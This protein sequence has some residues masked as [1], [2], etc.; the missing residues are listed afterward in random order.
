M[1]WS[2]CETIRRYRAIRLGEHG[3]GLLVRNR[4][5][6]AFLI[7]VM[8][9][10]AAGLL[11]SGCSP[12]SVCPFDSSLED[13]RD[14]RDVGFR[15]DIFDV[16]ACSGMERSPDLLDRPAVEGM[17][18]TGEPVLVI[19][20]F[21]IAGWDGGAFDL[22]DD[23]AGRFADVLRRQAGGGQRFVF[24]VI[25][26]GD[27]YWG[28]FVQLPTWMPAGPFGPAIAYSVETG[29]YGLDGFYGNEMGY[30]LTAVQAAWAAAR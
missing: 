14:I 2:S 23:L 15:I 4:L 24:R 12:A 9:V 3:D 25:A 28:H 29:Y 19:G 18:I 20:A 1:W 26:D 11:A 5:N 30:S 21:D 22:T 8:A 10:L 7:G 6:R 27:S 13:D 17:A 16:T